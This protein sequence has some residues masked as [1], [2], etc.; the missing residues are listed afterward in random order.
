MMPERILIVGTGNIGERHLRL[1][2]KNYPLS[3]VGVFQ[4]ELSSKN[5]L[6]NFD[7][8]F[9]I[10]IRINDIEPTTTENTTTTMGL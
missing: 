10:T 7:F 3:K 5:L 1:V 8:L 2:R 6:D 4:R 9:K